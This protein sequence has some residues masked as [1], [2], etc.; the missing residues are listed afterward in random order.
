MVR[1]KNKQG[2]CRRQ[3][4]EDL[5][6]HGYMESGEKDKFSHTL[7]SDIDCVCIYHW[8]EKATL[9]RD[10]RGGESCMEKNVDFRYLP[11]PP[12]PLGFGSEAL[13]F[14]SQKNA[15]AEMNPFQPAHVCAREHNFSTVFLRGTQLMEGLLWIERRSKRRTFDISPEIQANNPWLVGVFRLP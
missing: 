13:I 11:K 3:E 9:S 1:P 14:C 2:H 6:Q 15:Q 5:S 10:R 8:M 4:K 7:G 12:T